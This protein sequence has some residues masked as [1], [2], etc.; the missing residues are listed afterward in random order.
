MGDNYV[1]IDS[2]LAAK[3]T[4]ADARVNDLHD[5]LRAAEAM[6]QELLNSAIASKA[7]FKVGDDVIARGCRYRI[8]KAWLNAG[9]KR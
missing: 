6:R 4:E 9:H 2:E 5:Q 8:T 3:L 1:E 7:E